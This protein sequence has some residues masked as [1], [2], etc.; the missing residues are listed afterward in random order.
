M[1][2]TTRVVQMEPG[3]TPTLTPSTPALTRACAPSRVATLPPMTSTPTLDLIFAIQ[4]S[5]L[6][7]WPWDVSTMRKS[8]P[9]A[10]RP[11]ARSSASAAP[12]AAPTSSRPS[13]SLAA[14]GYF[15]ALTKSLTGMMFLEDAGVVDERQLL[16]LV[17][18]QQLHGVQAGDADLA[19]DQR[20]RGHDLAHLAA[21]VRLE[22]H[23]AVGDDAEQLA[24]RV[25]HRDAADAGIGH[26]ASA[27]ASVASGWTVIGRS[28]CR[29][30][31]RFTSST[32]VD[33]VPSTGQRRRMPTPPGRAMA[34]AMRTR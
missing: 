27:S 26:S 5:A 32:W 20:H 3:P 31:E 23:V 12:T 4:F 15:S 1:P 10:A 2:A 16:D 34:M 19:R 30:P 29:T 24:R 11:C 21:A 22:G 8:T 6:L 7:L 13:A 14:C 18:A 33:P 25:G 28:P 17:A 9:A